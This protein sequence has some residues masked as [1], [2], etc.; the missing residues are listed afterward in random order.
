[1]KPRWLPLLLTSLPLAAPAADEFW[2]LP[3]TL[4]LRFQQDGDEQRWGADLDQS[5]LA[6]YRLQL[7]TSFVSPYPR[8]KDVFYRL[9]L[10]SPPLDPLQTGFGLERWQ[11]DDQFKSSRYFGDLSW[12]N[13]YL[14]LGVSPSLAVIRIPRPTPLQEEVPVIHQQGYEGRAT[15]YFGEWFS[16]ELGGGRFAFDNDPRQLQDWLDSNPFQR[17]RMSGSS[18]LDFAYSLQRSRQ[19]LGMVL[20]WRETRWRLRGQRIEWAISGEE[21]EYLTVQVDYYASQKIS[22]TLFV[23]QDY[24]ADSGWFGGGITY[25][26]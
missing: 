12:R 14:M 1:M 6:D 23:G 20:R 19:S 13:R 16:L 10:F 9:A 2:A 26:W 7:G 5:L 18:Q 15:F 11:R 24:T 17:Q 8:D 25:S 22:I 4:S 3:S 21:S